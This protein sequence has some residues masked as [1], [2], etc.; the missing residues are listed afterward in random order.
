MLAQHY[1]FIAIGGI[2]MSA[3]ASILLERGTSVSGSDVVQSYVTKGLEKLGAKI[4]IGHA[5]ENLPPSAIIV[6]STAIT[7]D[8][9]EM[10]YAK[11]AGYPLIHRAELLAE[12]M[13]SH[14]ALLVA[15]THGKTT[16]SSLLAH[17]LVAA[18]ASP[19]FA[20]G[21]IVQ[22]LKKNGGAGS[23]PYFVAEACESDGTF[24]LYPGYGGIITNIDNDHLDYWKEMPALIDGYRRFIENMREKEHLY[25][26]ADDPVLKSLSTGTKEGSAIPTKT[27][28]FD[29]SADVRIA[30]FRQHG[31]KI[32]ID[33]EI[34]NRRYREIEIPLAGRHNA[35]NAA[36]VFALVLSLGITE[37]TIR[38][39]F[40]SFKGIARRL[41]KK[42]KMR[43]VEIYDDY[44]HHPT[45]I[46]ATL[47]AVREGLQG[48]RLVVAFQPHRYTRT[49]DCLEEFGPSFRAADLVY[50][51]DIYSAGEKP[52]PGIDT[53]ALMAHMQKANLRMLRYSSRRELA[54]HLAKALCKDDTLITMGAGDI[55]KVGGE[56]LALW[57]L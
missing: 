33:L 4:S 50:V 13:E 56:L 39:G 40:L 37:D 18:G 1:H 48:R 11:K 44:G 3:L 34:E 14:A 38:E 57:G 9:P 5:A 51:T 10:A 54:Q 35:Q 52:I 43:G 26:C 15:G 31:W 17:V 45:E 19:S 53:P 30:Q 7:A 20:V 55:T 6:Y 24:L 28:G 36:A 27:Y 23:G 32:A 47:E 2:G 29:L 12:L 41:E 46:A 16:V 22:S 42:G 8:N 21:G 49:R 25:L